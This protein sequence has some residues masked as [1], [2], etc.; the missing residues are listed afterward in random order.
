MQII[1]WYW[2]SNTASILKFYSLFKRYAN[3][4]NHLQQKKLF[5]GEYKD[6]ATKDAEELEIISER[7]F[8]FSSG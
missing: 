4:T 1:I 7:S 8:R 2:K 3:Y 6:L 5:P